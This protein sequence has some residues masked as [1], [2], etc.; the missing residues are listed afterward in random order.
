MAR[1]M[2]KEVK[3][4]FLFVSKYIFKTLKKFAEFFLEE[5]HKL[6]FGEKE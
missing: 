2:V 1:K 5:N 6:F 3:S 4:T